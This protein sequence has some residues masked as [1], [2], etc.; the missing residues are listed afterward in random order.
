MSR[1]L[2]WKLNLNF[3]L[4]AL[5]V[6]Q[7][8]RVFATIKNNSAKIYSE[9]VTLRENFLLLKHLFLHRIFENWFYRFHWDWKHYWGIVEGNRRFDDIASYTIKTKLHSSHIYKIILFSVVVY[10]SWSSNPDSASRHLQ[11]PANK[12]AL[13]MAGLGINIILDTDPRLSLSLR[14]GQH[15]AVHM[16]LITIPCFMVLL[17]HMRREGWL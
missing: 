9:M 12:Q 4:R 2:K 17:L 6:W 14:P 1:P 8:L 11:H 3:H 10:W 7:I 13:L 15:S 16:V 5:D